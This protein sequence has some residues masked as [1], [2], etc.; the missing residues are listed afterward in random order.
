MWKQNVVVVSHYV[1]CKGKHRTS[2]PE[3]CV[4]RSGITP[5][6]SLALVLLAVLRLVSGWYVINRCALSGTRTYIPRINYEGTA[7][8]AQIVDKHLFS[9]ERF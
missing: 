8:A 4:S 5:N 2:I 9:K 3:L 1:D 7:L 6:T